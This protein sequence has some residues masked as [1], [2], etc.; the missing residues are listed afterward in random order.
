M[1]GPKASPGKWLVLHGTHR[2]TIAS[3]EKERYECDSEEEAR[4]EFARA[5]KEYARM[6]RRTWYAHMYD[7]QGHETV[8]EAGQPYLR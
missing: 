4:A 1:D 6:G 5:K 2:G 7:D 3:R 8:L